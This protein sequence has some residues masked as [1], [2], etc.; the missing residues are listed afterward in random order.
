MKWVVVTGGGGGIGRGFVQYFSQAH[1]VLTCGRRLAALE[2]TK[3]GAPNPEH[4]HIVQADI[5]DAGQRAHFVA[6]LPED[7]QIML[8][9]QNAAIGDPGSFESISADHFEHA[10]RVNVVAPMALTQAFLPA[11]R[12]AGN[13]KVMHLGTSVAFRPQEGT[14]TYGVTKMAFHR[15]YQQIN[16]EKIGVACG[17]L[18]PGMVDT[19]GVIDHVQKARACNLPHVKFFDEAYSKNWLT[20]M[21]GPKSLM[22]FV[23][24]LLA[25]SPEEYASQEWKYSE[26]ASTLSTDPHPEGF[27]KKT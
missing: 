23:E 5:G 15:L 13:G 18:S 9:V 8:L 16:A 17:S 11:L 6:S 22:V 27:G 7:A 10:L 20:P 2:E 1:Q 19:E 4:V 21:E 24:H 25:M 26:W 3:V 12:R 14:L